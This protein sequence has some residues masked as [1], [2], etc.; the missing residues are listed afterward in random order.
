MPASPVS[1][2]LNHRANLERVTFYCAAAW[3]PLSLIYGLGGQKKYSCCVLGLEDKKKT[4][5]GLPVRSDSL[6]CIRQNTNEVV[7]KMSHEP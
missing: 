7:S 3:K 6:L 5:F 1:S 2:N 4:G